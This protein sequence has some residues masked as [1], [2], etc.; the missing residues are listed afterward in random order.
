MLAL[1]RLRLAPSGEQNREENRDFSRQHK[2]QWEKS[3]ASLLMLLLFRSIQGI[4]LFIFY[5]LLL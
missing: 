1:S 5:F 2:H 4:F 3:T